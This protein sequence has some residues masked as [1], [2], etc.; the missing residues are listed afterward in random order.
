MV[1]NT[2]DAVVINSSGNVGIGTTTPDGNS[3]LTIKNS[4]TVSNKSWHIG[5]DSSNSFLVYNQ[6]A[7]GVWVSDG[8]TSWN[9]SSDQRLKTNIQSLEASSTLSQILA[10]NP[11]SFAWKDVTQNALA[12]PQVGLI[13]Q[14]VQQVFPSLVAM[15]GTSTITL[16]DGSHEVVTNTLGVNYTGLIVPLI[17]AVQ[18]IANIT[19]AFKNALIA[20][21]GS[22]TNGIGEF[23]AAVIHSSEG[24]FTD[25]LC[26][27]AGA[28]ESCI[29]QS[30]LAALLSAAPAATIANPSPSSPPSSPSSGTNL[31]GS[32]T[33][34]VIQVNGNNPATIIVGSTYADLGATIVSPA[35]DTNLGMTVLVDSATSTDGIATISTTFP[36]TH[37]ITYTVTNP[38]GLT[39]LATRTVTV[40]AAANDNTPQANASTTATS[41]AP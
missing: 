1:N 19:G 20:W 23:F 8:G 22:A 24:H 15:S 40:A 17:K 28:T 3:P 11:V 38:A 35:A 34:P 41:T 12:G 27:G 29:N 33:A 30:Q 2:T 4:G 14:Q 32:T 36:G 6:G 18:D 25:K 21:L 16:A 31:Q 13:A 39:G 9:S 10:L 26:I 7:A 5:P 37:T